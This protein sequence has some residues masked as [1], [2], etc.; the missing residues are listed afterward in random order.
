MLLPSLCQVEN[1]TPPARS[2]HAHK[3]QVVALLNCVLKN[4]RSPEDVELLPLLRAA[5]D[6]YGR[7]SFV[8]LGAYDGE[9]GSQSWLLEKCF[10]WHGLLIEAVRSLC[11]HIV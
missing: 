6:M 3:G 9:E 7:P 1:P 8:E 4:Q 2:H 10:G 5:S 11:A